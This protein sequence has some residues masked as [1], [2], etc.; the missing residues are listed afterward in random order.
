MSFYSAPDRKEIHQI[1]LRIAQQIFSNK[2]SKKKL[3]ALKPLIWSLKPE[4]FDTIERHYHNHFHLFYIASEFNQE[5]IKI[6]VKLGKAFNIKSS[7]AFMLILYA[8]WR[9]EVRRDTLLTMLESSRDLI[10]GE[11]ISQPLQTFATAVID[12]QLETF[13]QLPEWLHEFDAGDF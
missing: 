10:Q 9:Y 13:P 8:K 2:S 4:F 5:A 12:F 11:V 3:S 6:S 1:A 7:N